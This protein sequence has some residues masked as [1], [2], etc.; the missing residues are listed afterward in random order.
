MLSCHAIL[1]QCWQET[2]NAQNME[3]MMDTRDSTRSLV[4]V[5]AG[6]RTVRFCAD[7]GS[8]AWKLHK[9]VCRMDS[10]PSTPAYVPN[11]G[12]IDTVSPATLCEAC[13]CPE[14]G[15]VECIHI[16][17]VSQVKESQLSRLPQGFRPR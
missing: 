8:K 11:S 5:C 15:Q 9:D 7:C 1:L 6:C 17:I 4:Q 13:H 10:L 16:V 14:C 2:R 3:N 12:V